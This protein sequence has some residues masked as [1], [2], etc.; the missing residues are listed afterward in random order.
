MRKVIIIGGGAAGM[1]AAVECARNGAAVVLYEKNEKLGKKLFITGKGRCNLTNACDMEELQKSVMRN[2]KFM[3]SS[4]QNFSNWEALGFFE[5]LGVATKIERGNR[6]FPVSDHSSDVIGALEQELE[7]LQVKVFRKQPVAKLN[8]K[9]GKV[10][11]I[12]LQN[13]KTEDADAVIVATGGLSYPLTGS[14]GDGF[15]FAKAMGHKITDTSPALVPLTCAEPWVCSL[16]GLSL[17]NINAV[18]K[19][20]S[21]V[22]YDGFGEMLFTHFGVSGPLIL[23]ASSVILEDLRKENLTL[24]IDLKPALL[25]EQLDD[26]ILRDF[27]QAKNKQFKNVLGSLL[28]AKLIPVVILLSGITPEKKVNEINKKERKALLHTLK[29]LTMTVNGVCGYEEAIITRGGVDVKEINP[30]TM[31]SK[32]VKNLYFAGEV[33]DV[34]ALTGGFNLQIAWS[35]A[36]AAARAASKEE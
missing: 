12:T 6:V 22:I 3:Y 21:K 29:S 35:T 32:K 20:G 13:G 8:Q 19:K 18:V 28:P 26:R 10:S 17:K 24:S 25:P 33:L 11:S 30:S 14:T 23:S 2:P 7:R 5:E 31:E 15:S 27:S 1:M 36:M 4:F 34:D 16:Q 9:N